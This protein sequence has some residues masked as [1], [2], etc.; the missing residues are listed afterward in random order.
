MFGLDTTLL[1]NGV[2]TIAWG[3]TD[4]TGGAAGVG[5][6]YFTV[7]NGSSV[8]SSQLSASGFQLPASGFQLPA[9]PAVTGRRGFELDA[10]YRTFEAGRDGVVTIDSEEVDRIELQFDAGT[11]GYMRTGAHLGR[12]PIGARVDP[13][14]GVFTWQPGAGFVGAYDFVFVSAGTRR[15]IRIVLHPKGHNR[16]GP[17]IVIDRAS[18]D[19]AGWA[20]DLDSA[21]GS[22]ISA[23]HV[24]AYPSG[25]PSTGAPIF[26]GEAEYG[27]VRP[28]VAA[29]YGE[30]F[31]RS[32]YGIGLHGLAPG[33][34]DLAVF[35]Y[36]SVTG[37][38]GP[39]KTTR[40]VIGEGGR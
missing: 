8:V 24:W 2:H 18:P 37:R 3:V 21:T 9:E 35:G 13:A 23:I 29:L 28:D 1:T 10:P 15:D 25:G 20:V 12:L 5:S 6:R 34:Y 14:T 33:T 17:T 11:E 30:R 27:G 7:S 19:L 16:Q 39:A 32:G 26:V 36:S 31:A 4:N 22:G 40:V 38:F